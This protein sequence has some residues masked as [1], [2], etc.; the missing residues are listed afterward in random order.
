MGD[1][2]TSDEPYTPDDADISAIT[3]AL[4]RKSIA[5]RAE[6]KPVK[7]PPKVHEGKSRLATD[8]AFS[9]RLRDIDA[10]LDSGSPLSD[11]EADYMS[12]R[13][14]SRLLRS[15]RPMMVARAVALLQ[16]SRQRKFTGPG[17]PVALPPS[18]VDSP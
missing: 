5:E 2:L 13:A 12:H 3:G 18:E 8:E 17:T 7:P 1:D 4:S 10:K 11:E 9:E 14:I 6:A 15:N 16:V